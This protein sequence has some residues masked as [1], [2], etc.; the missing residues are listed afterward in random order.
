MLLSDMNRCLNGLL[1]LVAVV[2]ACVWYAYYANSKRPYDDPKKK[3][4]HPFAILLAPI[5]LPLFVILYILIFILRAA[6]YGVFLVL[7][8]LA[9]ILI[10]KPFIFEWLKKIALIIGNLLLEA[11]TLLIRIFLRPLARPSGSA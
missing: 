3:H 2:I 1:F 10:R 11:N 5:T 8:A 7:F 6:T 4:Y 9:L